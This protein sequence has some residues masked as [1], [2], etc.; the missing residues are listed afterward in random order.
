MKHVDMSTDGGHGENRRDRPGPSLQ[1]LGGMLR[2]PI[3]LF[4]PAS[5]TRDLLIN[6]HVLHHWALP[7]CS[8]GAL[9]FHVV[10][11]VEDLP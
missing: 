1:V 7:R 11:E 3:P 6:K 8:S 2:R 10:E 5:A 4:R 9:V